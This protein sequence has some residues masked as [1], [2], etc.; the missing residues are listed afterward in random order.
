VAIR[1]IRGATTSTQDDPEAILS[2]TKQ[3][4]VAI[5]KA[6]PTLQSEE[7]ASAIFTLSDDLKSIYPARAARE[8]GWTAVPLI[9]A[10]E[11]PVPGGLS[12]CIRVLLNWNTPLSQADVNHIYL[13]EAKQLRPDLTPDHNVN[14]Y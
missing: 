2:A 6:N 8:I 3:L 4:L 10:Q 13:R 14:R 7:I 5:C 11:I 9:C 1:G 12:K